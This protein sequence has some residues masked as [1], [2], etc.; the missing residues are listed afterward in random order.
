VPAAGAFHPEHIAMSSMA[1][2]KTKAKAGARK[3]KHV[4][5]GVGMYFRTAVELVRTT[6]INLP[7]AKEGIQLRCET[8]TISLSMEAARRLSENILALIEADDPV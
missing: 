6:Y 1:K 4:G 3:M 7:D 8:V 5:A 2:T